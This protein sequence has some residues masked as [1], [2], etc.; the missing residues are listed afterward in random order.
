MNLVLL[1]VVETI[2]V[3]TTTAMAGALGAAIGN[4]VN[5]TLS[6]RKNNE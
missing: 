1:V 4:Q 2:L 3:V 5:S 6:N